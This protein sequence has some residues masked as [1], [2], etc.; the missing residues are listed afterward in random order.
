[1]STYKNNN[2]NPNKII[3]KEEELTQFQRAC[4]EVNVNLIHA[5]SP[6]AK[7]RVERLFHTLQ[8][9]LT[10]EMRLNNINTIKQ[11]NDFLIEV[12]VPKFNKKFGVQPVSK[13]DFHKQLT[14]NQLSNLYNSFC[15]KHKRKVMNDFTVRF[16]NVYYQIL[17]DQ[18]HR[19]LRK[20]NV[21]VKKHL[22]NTI[23]LEHKGFDIKYTALIEKPLPEKKITVSEI[24]KKMK[25]YTPPLDHP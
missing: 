4:S 8:D 23:C 3:P 17:K 25:K 2:I 1:V 6:Q 16:D 9:R 14:I 5:K 11:A 10:K 20:S 7:G 18:K 24:K 13:I 15:I 21:V 12:F 22:D 19:V